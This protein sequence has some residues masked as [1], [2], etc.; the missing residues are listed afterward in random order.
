VDRELIPRVLALMPAVL[1]ITGDH[2][3]PAVMAGHSWHP[4]PVL[5]HGARVRTQPAAGFGETEC[6]RGALGRMPGMY[7][8]AE[9]LAAAG[10]LTKYGA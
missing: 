4:V 1:A 6:A 5:L 10:R 9:M 8:M 3:T 2:S 7:L